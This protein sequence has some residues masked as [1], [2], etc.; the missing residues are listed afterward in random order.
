MSDW[1]CEEQEMDETTAKQF[2]DLVDSLF[3]LK[4][5]IEAEDQ[6]LKER[7][8]ELELKKQKVR[9]FLQEYGKQKHIGRLGSVSSGQRLSVK[10]P[11][12]PEAKEAFFKY[13]KE[14][15]IFE[16]LVSVHSRTLQT[17]Y[18]GEM[19][20]ALEDGD[21]DYAMPGIGEPTYTETL[22][23]RRSK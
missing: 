10:V 16:D 23:M 12:D 7:K 21:I 20:A 6:R 14:K 4:S 2:E 13:L 3:T 18:K 9:A 1:F 22:T 11:Q 8:Q 19:E 5:E 15:G 17:F